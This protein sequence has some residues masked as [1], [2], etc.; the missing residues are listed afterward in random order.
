MQL[1]KVYSQLHSEV[2]QLLFKVNQARYQTLTFTDALLYND[3]G[4]R[5]Q[6]VIVLTEEFFIVSFWLL[7]SVDLGSTQHL[8]GR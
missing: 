2:Q 6:K 3:L 1:I 8:S 5:K 4:E 7:L